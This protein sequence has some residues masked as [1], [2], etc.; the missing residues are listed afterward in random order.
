MKRAALMLFAVSIFIVAAA[1]SALA[2]RGQNAS[3]EQ[4]RER[5]ATQIDET[6][7]ALELK[8]DRAESIKAILV[9]QGE[10]SFEIQTEMR[11]ARGAAGQ[12]QDARAAMAGFRERLTAVDAETATM[13]TQI[14]TEDELVKYTELVASRQ[15]GPR[16]R[17]AQV[18]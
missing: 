3:P 7:A 13:L 15:R 1:P 12:G 14:L 11:N 17:G 4:M 16:G 9:A 2:Q 6:V 8:G 5:M 18:N 10:K